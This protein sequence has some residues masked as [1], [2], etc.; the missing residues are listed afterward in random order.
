MRTARWLLLAAILIIAAATGYVYLTQ[1]KAAADSAP[2]PAIPLAAG[3][4]GTA[5]EWHFTNSNGGCPSLQVLAKNF[6]QI[7]EP[8]T[9]ELDDVDLRLFHNCGK[10]FDHVKA[11]KAQ[12]DTASGE[13]Y[14]EGAV[15][16]ERG[17]P[18][19]LET[20]QPEEPSGRLVKMVSTEAPTVHIGKPMARM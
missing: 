1:K 13:M 3:V 20:G 19:N 14:S 2:K 9:G 6:R 15:E 5:K 18:F 11:A 17:L 4:E 8:S 10:S 12:F 7:R 16:L